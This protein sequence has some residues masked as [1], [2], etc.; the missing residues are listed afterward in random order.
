MITVF[1]TP[2]E[3]GQTPNPDSISSHLYRPREPITPPLPDRQHR[4]PPIIIVLPEPVRNVQHPIIYPKKG[5]D[6]HGE[7]NGDGVERREDR[8]GDE[9]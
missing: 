7:G 8:D 1:L 3:P 4:F 9:Q 6:P 5:R 2:I